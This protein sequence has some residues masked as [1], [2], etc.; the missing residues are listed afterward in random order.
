[1]KSNV[2][3]SPQR[4]CLA[5]SA[6]ARVLARRA[7]CRPRR[8]RPCCSDRHVLRRGEQLDVAGDRAR[9]LAGAR[10]ALAHRREV[11]ADPPG[12]RCVYEVEPREAGLAAG[13][14]AVAA[15]GEEELRVAARAEAAV[16]DPLAADPA[17]LEL[18]RGSR[19]RRS[20]R[21]S[22]MTSAPW[23][24]LLERLADLVAHLVAAGSDPGPDRRRGPR[25]A[26][27][28]SR[29]PLERRASTMPADD[30]RASRSGRR[31]TAPGAA[32]SERNAVGDQHQRREDGARVTCASASRSGAP[33]RRG[34]RSRS[35]RRRVPCTWRPIT[36]RAGIAA[37]RRARAAR[38][39]RARGPRSSSVRMP[40]LSER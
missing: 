23:P 20:S 36:T 26:R 12:S 17:A 30:A 3:R 7:R 21:P 14:A 16:G 13:D 18:A 8:A 22:G 34:G 9:P 35:L 15:V 28:S 38:G 4:S 24:R 31:A 40:R 29:E 27:R 25:R 32:S 1:M 2:K 37:E 11:R 33:I 6:C 10:D 39:S 19:A 5:A